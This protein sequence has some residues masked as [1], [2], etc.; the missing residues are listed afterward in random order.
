MSSFQEVFKIDLNCVNGSSFL[1]KNYSEY[2]FYKGT[3]KIIKKEL[4]YDVRCSIYC[5]EFICK[6]FKT[7]FE[8]MNYLK[9][10]SKLLMKGIFIYFPCLKCKKNNYV[11]DKRCKCGNIFKNKMFISL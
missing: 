10:A 2:N 6:E 9:I 7:Y 3:L 4:T 1:K 11:C 5:D 8:A